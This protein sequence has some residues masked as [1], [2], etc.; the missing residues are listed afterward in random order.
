MREYFFES[1]KTDNFVKII[2]NDNIVEIENYHIDGDSYENMLEFCDILKCAFD[3]AKAD[4][5]TYFCQYVD[6]N[7]WCDNLKKD[8][9]WELINENKSYCKIMSDI[10]DAPSCIMNGFL[11]NNEI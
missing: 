6:V 7:E 10:S 9:R 3:K 8:D 2:A 11:I 4:G 5:F 1:K